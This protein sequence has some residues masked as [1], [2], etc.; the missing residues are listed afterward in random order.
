MKIGMAIL[1]LAA[2]TNAAPLL[3]F[4]GPKPTTKPVVLSS[5]D[6]GYSIRCDNQ[7]ITA[8]YEAAGEVCHR[9]YEIENQSA[10]QGYTQGGFSNGG[11]SFEGGQST[12]AIGI[13][14]RCKDPDLTEA[15]RNQKIEMERDRRAKAEQRRSDEARRSLKVVAIIGGLGLAALVAA[16]VVVSVVEG[17]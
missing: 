5:G 13:L 1:T 8:C 12:S 17:K 6:K 16:G 2:L 10:E 3:D 14:I 7:G 9:G 11:T 15:E 4:S